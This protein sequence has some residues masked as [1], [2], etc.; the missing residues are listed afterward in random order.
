MIGVVASFAMNGQ[1][2]F[3]VAVVTFAFL[4]PELLLDIPLC[5]N[6]TQSA[7]AR[8]TVAISRS[9]PFRMAFSVCLAIFFVIVEAIIIM[10]APTSLDSFAIGFM[11]LAIILSIFAAYSSL[12]GTRFINPCQSFRNTLLGT[13]CLTNPMQSIF[14]RLQ[15]MEIF[16]CGNDVSTTSSATLIAFWRIT[17]Q[18]PLRMSHTIPGFLALF[19]RGIQLVE[20]ELMGIE[21]L[22]GCRKRIFALRTSLVAIGDLWFRGLGLLL[23]GLVVGIP[24][25]PTVCIKPVFATRLLDKKLIGFREVVFAGLALLLRNVFRGK[26]IH[27]V[28][29]CLPFSSPCCWCCQSGKATARSPG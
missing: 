13:T 19:A 1:V 27:R 14:F 17:Y 4:S 16:Q 24:A 12:I 18:Y 11:V 7:Q 20:S 29:N 15:C 26:R 21:K 9:A 6:T 5:K 25:L 22:I 8:S 10:L 23:V 28:L 2:D 3:G